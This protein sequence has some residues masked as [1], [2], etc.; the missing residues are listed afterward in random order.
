MTTYR[1]DFDS[2]LAGKAVAAGARRVSSTVATGLLREADGRISG[3]RTDRAD[4]RS[5]PGSYRQRG[6]LVLTGG[7]PAAAHQ[8]ATP[9][10]A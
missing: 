4:R 10:W 1:A 8:P 2:W 6:G 3:V 5:A 7:R 9:R